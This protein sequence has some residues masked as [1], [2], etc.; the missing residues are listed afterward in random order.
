MTGST[1]SQIS[2][3]DDR[4]ARAHWSIILR[5][6]GHSADAR[7]SLFELVRRYDYPVYA[8]VRRCGHAP[9]VARAVTQTFLQHLLGEFQRGNDLRPAAHY[10]EYLLERLHGFLGS[11]GREAVAAQ[12]A[13][14]SPAAPDMEARYLRDHIKLDSPDHAFQRSFALEVLHRALGHLREEAKQTGHVKMFSALEPFLSHDPAAGVYEQLA[15]SLHSRPLVLVMALKRLRQRL[16]ELTGKELADTVGGADDL[17]AE[18]DIL[19]SVLR[20]RAR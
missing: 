17:S 8:Y 12:S 13:A 15:A 16:R 1:H 18:Q 4:F 9:E 7:D 11:D 10:R 2:L 3:P 19:L 6:A 20:E 14:V 5:Q